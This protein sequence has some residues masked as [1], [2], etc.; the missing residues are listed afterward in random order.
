MRSNRQQSDS[1]GRKKSNK[2]GKEN[3]QTD[4]RKRKE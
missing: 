4:E 3:F 2:N 1:K